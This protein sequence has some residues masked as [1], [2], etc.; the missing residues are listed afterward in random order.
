MTDELYDWKRASVTVSYNTSV[1]GNAG[2][3]QKDLLLKTNKEKKKQKFKSKCAKLALQHATCRRGTQQIAGVQ[4]TR[5]PSWGSPGSQPGSAS[6]W[7]A[8]RVKEWSGGKIM[9][10]SSQNG[11]RRASKM[12]GVISN[13]QQQQQGYMEE[14]NSSNCGDRE[15]QTGERQWHSNQLPS[16]G[17][18]RESHSMLINSL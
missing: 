16:S 2:E 17:Q 14:L 5:W 3:Q 11:M 12:K 8:L 9:G 6:G 4:V 10:I 15:H 18:Q 1:W 7:G 13:T